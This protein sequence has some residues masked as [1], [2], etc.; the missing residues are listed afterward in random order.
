MYTKVNQCIHT[1]TYTHTCTH[2]IL[3]VWESN[4]GWGLLVC[5]QLLW[6]D[7][8]CQCPYCDRGVWVWQG[9][10][11][12]P[13]ARCHSLNGETEGSEEI[14]PE[15]TVHKVDHWQRQHQVRDGRGQLSR[16]GDVCQ[17]V[18]RLWDEWLSETDAQDSFQ[19]S[20]ASLL[21]QRSSTV[22]LPILRVLL[23][24]NTS[25]RLF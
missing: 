20:T 22:G 1:H 24:Y 10:A 7:R 12:N 21:L 8:F 19:P 13:C 9:K 15:H 11:V 3:C 17:R 16:H 5:L 18:G 23:A 2:T 4:G 14:I 25:D 6:N